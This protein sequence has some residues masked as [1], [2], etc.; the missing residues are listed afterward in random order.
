MRHCIL[1]L[2]ALSALACADETEDT[3]DSTGTNLGAME[4]YSIETET[5][6]A[7]T[8]EEQIQAFSIPEDAVVLSI[9]SCYE[10][11]GGVCYSSEYEFSPEVDS[12]RISGTASLYNTVYYM[13]PQ[14]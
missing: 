2:F 13:V 5:L 4:F 14:N 9:R 1:A 10:P 12:Y 7:N 3:G 6:E 11:E 8:P